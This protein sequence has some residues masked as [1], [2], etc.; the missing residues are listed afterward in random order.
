M[1]YYALEA[2]TAR[3][4]VL[5]ETGSAEIADGE[6]VLTAEETVVFSDVFDPDALFAEAKAAGEFEGYDSLDALLAANAG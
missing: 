3:D 1:G 2:C 5:Y 4:E 6:L